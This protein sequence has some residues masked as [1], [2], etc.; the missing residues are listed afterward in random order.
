MANSTAYIIR[1]KHD[2][3]NRV[4][5]LEITGSLLYHLE[6]SWTLVHKRLKIGPGIFI[7]VRLQAAFGTNVTPHNES[8]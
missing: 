6:I 2:V 1:M 5:V 3:D 4:N 7:L 8:A